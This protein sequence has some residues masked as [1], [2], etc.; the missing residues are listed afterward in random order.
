M[1]PK[2]FYKKSSNSASG[3]S[4]GF[5][6]SGKWLII[7]ESPSKCKKIEEYVGD[8]YHCIASKGHIRSI[9]GLKSID[10]KRTFHPTFV[11]M[12]EKRAHVQTMLSIIEQFPKENIL[13]ASDD[14]REGESIAW[15]ICVVFGLPVET[16]KRVL[17]HEIT[18]D[19]V[20][21]AVE[22]PTRINMSLVYAQHSRQVLDV[23]VGYTLS[24]M[25]WKHIY[26]DKTNGLS[27]GRC[28]TPALR[29]IYD[30]HVDQ[31]EEMCETAYKIQG[32]F[33]DKSIRFDFSRRYTTEEDVAVF[34]AKTP[35]HEHRLS[36]LPSKETIKS[37]PKPFTTSRLLQT[38]SSVLH[39]SP[40]MTMDL[41][42]Q[43]YQSGLITYMRTDS[44]K[45][46]QV[47]L[48]QA[49][50]FIIKEYI[51]SRYVGNLGTLENTDAA[52]PHEA[53]RVTNI[54]TQFITDANKSL[55]SMY[56][57]IWRNTVESCMSTAKYDTTHVQISSPDPDAHYQHTLEIPVFLGWKK[58]N[59]A[60]D[61]SAGLDHASQQ[62]GLLLYFRS[63]SKTPIQYQYIESQV[64]AERRHAHYCEASLIQKMEELG[65]GRPSTFASIVETIQ[66]RGYV[67]KTDVRGTTIRCR[68]HKM[69]RNEPVQITEK[70]RV[71]GNEKGKLVIQPTGILVVDFLMNYFDSL[72]SYH[73]T[74]DM[75]TRLDEIS[76]MSAS[77]AETSWPEICREC[78]TRIKTLKKPL[79]KITRETYS[80]GENRE[81]VFHTRGASIKITKE[82]GTVEYKTVKKTAQIDL[83]KLKNGEYTFEELVE[84]PDEHLG[85]LDDRNI[86]LK[87]GRYGLY[88]EWGDIKVSLTS[89]AKPADEIGMEDVL[90]LLLAK[91]PTLDLSAIPD[92]YQSASLG[93]KPPTMPATRVLTPQLSVRKGKYGDYV[94]CEKPGVKKPAF[95]NI[96]KYK[97]DCWN[98]DADTLV[99]WL[100]I[101]YS[102]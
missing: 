69:R 61:D 76:S 16:T 39:F 52:N 13:I 97:G 23:I 62:T 88:A 4:G 21:A 83:G 35:T 53:I 101:T 92:T 41:C 22:T 70:E 6:K 30:H 34:L 59:A 84:I 63:M 98:D 14:D 45:Y 71:F 65:I 58:V 80:L 10:T 42:Q 3:S 26:N 9:D 100:T 81:V 79:S 54:H 43:L 60:A 32:Y 74:K 99:R 47:F 20:R 67:K 1:P 11:L 85:V 77:E 73:Y 2:R 7:V 96:K 89:L 25:L 5:V 8:A 86:L 18:R 82:D 29:L 19:A 64:S 17:F 48:V 56:R 93:V 31:S 66:E 90:P 68:E 95:L 50:A 102:L 78:Y 38:A 87:S 37:P 49:E 51:D 24:P 75:E 40:K 46:S 94:Y 36:I 27:A 72:F 15:H 33:S 55:V 12:D 57:F 91:E 28:Q 44:A